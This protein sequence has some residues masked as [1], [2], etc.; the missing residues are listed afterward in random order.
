MKITDQGQFSVHAPKER[1]VQLMTDPDF[2]GRTL[3]D[4]KGYRVT[5]PDSVVADMKVGVSHIKGVM[6]TT[7]TI[8]AVR[9]GEPLT[10]RV[11]AQGLGSRVDMELAFD[12]KDLN[13][14]SDL[15][16]SSTATVS[17]MLASVGSGLLRP[18]AKRNFD[19]IVGA[20]RDAIEA[21]S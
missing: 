18:M 4:S 14:S 3:P 6:P 19:A 12:I 15:D 21:A 1:V 7:L 9:E 20:I 5:G 8:K 11:V 16:W 13:G 17:G 10:I 2:L